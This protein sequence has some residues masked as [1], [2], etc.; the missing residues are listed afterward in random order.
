V[1][2]DSWGTKFSSRKGKE[3]RYRFDLG[4]QSH[5]QRTFCIEPGQMLGLARPTERMSDCVARRRLSNMVSR[6][7]Y[8]SRGLTRTPLGSPT[9]RRRT[10]PICSSIAVA[11][12][13]TRHC[14]SSANG[15]RI[16]S[17]QTQGGTSIPPRGESGAA[18]FV[19]TNP[20]EVA[21]ERAAA[22]FGEIHHSSAGCS[23]GEGRSRI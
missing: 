22:A 20:R 2:H 15:P 21:R 12:G 10:I 11:P 1:A 19:A 17:R 14:L 23:S 3:R 8:S 7:L 16:N 6:A 5:L 4:V 13:E 9:W 18:G